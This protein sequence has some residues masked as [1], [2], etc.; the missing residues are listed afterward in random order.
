MASLPSHT[1][2]S[3]HN[4]I[5]PHVSQTSRAY[6]FPDILDAEYILLNTH[7]DELWPLQDQKTF[8]EYVVLLKSG[9][10][11]PPVKLPFKK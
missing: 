4:Q 7:I 2:I 6:I 5:S 1:S 8:E 11:L 10:I 9:K 3:T